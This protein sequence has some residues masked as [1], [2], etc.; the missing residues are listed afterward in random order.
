MTKLTPEERWRRDYLARDHAVRTGRRSQLTFTD[1]LGHTVYLDP[2][3]IVAC[4]F[5]PEDETTRVLLRHGY[6]F[7]VLGD[8]G[9]RISCWVGGV[10][11]LEWIE[12]DGELHCV[13]DDDDL[14]D[15]EELRRERKSG[16]KR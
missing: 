9:Y 11:P 1:V 2:A 4:V 3:Y 8:A 6:S 10:H 16:G 14:R 7:E 5:N 15:Y 13:H 12:K